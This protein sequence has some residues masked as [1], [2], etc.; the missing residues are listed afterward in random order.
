MRISAAVSKFGPGY[1]TTRPPSEGTPLLSPLFVT[2]RGFRIVGI[3][4][5]EEALTKTFIIKPTIGVPGMVLM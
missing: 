3:R 2:V 1:E 5:R 4:Q